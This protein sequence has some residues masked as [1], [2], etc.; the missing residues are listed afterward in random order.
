M[1]DQLVGAVENEMRHGV[2]RQDLVGFRAAAAGIVGIVVEERDHDPPLT[3]MID[4]IVESGGVLR[5][6]GGGAV[7]GQAVKGGRVGDHGVDLVARARGDERDPGAARLPGEDDLG[8][9]LLLELV[10]AADQLIRR[11]ARLR[12]QAWASETEDV[13]AGVAQQPD[14]QRRRRR[15]L[16]AENGIA[17]VIPDDRAFGRRRA[18][19][20]RRRIGRRE[21]E[22][23]RR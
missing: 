23:L 6:V 22:F 8:I 12:A 5:D 3:D 9:A 10:H 18:L 21:L 7:G 20:R 2:T 17:A 11:D 15:P 13:P 19:E 1:P 4:L 16:L 14:E